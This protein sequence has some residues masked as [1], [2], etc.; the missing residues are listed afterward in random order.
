MTE[1]APLFDLVTMGRIGVD[2]YPPQSGVSLTLVQTF[3]KFLGGSAANVAVAAARSGRSSAVIP[4]TG[5]DPFGDR[6][7][8]A[9]KE[10]GIDDRWVTPAEGLRTPVTHGPLS[11]WELERTRRYAVA[12]PRRAWQAP[13][14]SADEAPLR[15]RSEAGD[16]LASGSHR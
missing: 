10:F 1:S 11:G 2:L 12:K 3:G 9:L 15:S 5:A 8:E 14:T 4:R 16:L 6:L 7:H 13:L